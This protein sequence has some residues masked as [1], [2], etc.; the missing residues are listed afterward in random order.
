MNFELEYIEKIHN[1]LN[2]YA[3]Q[4]HHSTSVYR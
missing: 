1:L 4:I 2:I 3:T